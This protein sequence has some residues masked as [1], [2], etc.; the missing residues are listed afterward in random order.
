M[1]EATILLELVNEIGQ[2]VCHGRAR[3]LKAIALETVQI[4]GGRG[5][6]THYDNEFILNRENLLRQKRVA[7][8]RSSKTKRSVQLINRTIGLNAR[9]CLRHASP[10]HQRRLAFVSGFGSDRHLQNANGEPARANSPFD[11]R[12]LVRLAQRRLRLGFFDQ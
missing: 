5:E 4:F 6:F 9:V 3:S 2:S 11:I 1:F 8:I 7:R 12:T 10:I